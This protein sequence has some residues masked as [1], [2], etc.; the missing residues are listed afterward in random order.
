MLSLTT[1][2]N[3]VSFDAN[4]NP[5]DTEDI[6]FTL[7]SQNL[8]GTVSWSV[9]P[10]NVSLTS[11]STTK[12][13]IPTTALI[14]ND[15][16]KVTVS[17]EEDSISD[18]VTVVKVRDGARGTSINI[19]NEYATEEEL[20][21]AHPTGN[22]NDAYLV[23]G[24]LYVW[25]E[26]KWT[27][28]GLFKGR[29]GVDGT[30]YYIHIKYSDDGE[31]FT[32]NDGEDVGAYIGILTDTNKADSRVFSDY[33][34]KKIEGE[35]GLNG[36]DAYTV[37]LSNESHAFAGNT[38]YAIAGET[39]CIVNG[40]KGSTKVKCTI[41]KIT[42]IPTGMTVTISNNNTTDATF[43]VKVD[44]TMSTANGTL[45]I[46]VTIDGKVITKTF[47]YAIA[48]KGADS[49]TLDLYADKYVVPFKEDNTLKDTSVI[50][51]KAYPKNLNGT[52]TWSTTPSISL[53]GSG[54]TRTIDPN[55][56]KN[57]NSVVVS[58][59]LGGYNDKITIVKIKDGSKGANG[60][61]GTNGVNGDDAI[62]IVLSNPSHTFMGD[63]TKAKASST[64]CKVI[65]YKGTQAIACKIGTITGMPTGMSI[66]NNGTHYNNNTTGAY[67]KVDVTTEMTT[68]N[69]TL[70]VPVTCDGKSFN[71][72]F[73]YS[74]ALKGQY[75]TGVV[76]I[77]EEYARN[78]DKTTAPTSGWS[79]NPPVWEE[80]YYLWTRSKITYK[81]PTKTEYTTP[82]CDSSW[83]ALE[84]L[85]IGGKNELRYTDFSKDND[86][87]SENYILNNFS[88]SNGGTV[89]LTTYTFGKQL[90]EDEFIK[91]KIVLRN[92]IDVA[93][94][95]A[96]NQTYSMTTW[97]ENVTLI[98]NTTYTL[99]MYMYRGG[100][101]T[102]KGFFQVFPVLEDGS[103]GTRVCISDELTTYEGK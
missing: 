26:S 50:T 6:V 68:G 61:N 73:S 93:K 103:L 32:L 94:A 77:I 49:Q 8:I 51:L 62:T 78:K 79:T 41:G 70:T 17:S 37:I 13:K 33:T 44:D 74:L 97:V 11:I 81:N 83:E 16:I 75:G 40:Y 35:Q 71:L 72:M 76:S 5:K 34:W 65:A 88:A 91:N 80:G 23:N 42:G 20:N 57:N 1:N 53:G 48:F 96:N 31:S 22:I 82:I 54:N 59:T 38:N 99:S 14:N 28:V 24:Y 45:E 3:V 52:V 10:S 43:I 2:K 55:V 85:E 60:T 58:A 90:A 15:N 19:L 64:T 29:D 30:S 39:S 66:T 67:F 98:P 12:K 21:E 27:N 100:A 102:G 92:R 46:P 95:I 86:P 69:G 63:E 18:V 36:E 84:S 47:S 89:G 4:D 87:E 7:N 101:S 25:A 56:F 9:S